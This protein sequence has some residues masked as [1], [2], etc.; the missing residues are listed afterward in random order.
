MAPGA[1]EQHKTT[2]QQR[3]TENYTEAQPSRERL[4]PVRC[5]NPAARHRVL[6][7][8]ADSKQATQA[9]MDD[10]SLLVKKAK[11]AKRHKEAVLRCY[12]EGTAALVTGVEKK[13]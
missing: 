5:R 9:N 10:G 13:T 2:P 8:R 12:P 4:D 1:G 3:K 11:R 6:A 7:M